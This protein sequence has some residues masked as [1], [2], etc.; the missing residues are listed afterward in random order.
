MNMQQKFLKGKFRLSADIN[1]N[2]WKTFV[3]KWP[4]FLKWIWGQH[5]KKDYAQNLRKDPIMAKLK[6]FRR[7]KW[8]KSIEIQWNPMKSNHEICT[9]LWKSMTRFPLLYNILHI[10]CVP[11]HGNRQNRPNLSMLDLRSTCTPFREKGFM[12]PKKLQNAWTYF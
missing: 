9:V 1:Q 11:L 5:I 8:K 10:I 3:K 7:F 2:F 12:P 6:T 4:K